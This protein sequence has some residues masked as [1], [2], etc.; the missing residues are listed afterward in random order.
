MP[1]FQSN[2]RVNGNFLGFIDG[3][4]C[5]T[6]QQFYTEIA[7]AL[8]F[9]DY[10]GNNLDALDEALCDLSWI[11]EKTILLLIFHYDKFMSEDKENLQVINAVFSH[12]I[13]ELEVGEIYFTVLT[14]Q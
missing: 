4:K 12:A 5:T 9:P 14:Q 7:K 10:F 2:I 1:N 13:S 6:L 8:E 3:Q 11:E